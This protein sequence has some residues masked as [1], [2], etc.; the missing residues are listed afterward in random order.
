MDNDC[1][2]SHED[3]IPGI[4]KRAE[5]HLLKNAHKK[6]TLGFEDLLHPIILEYAYQQFRN[7]HLRDAVL[8]SVIAVFEYIRSR[9]GLE[10]DG[11]NLV[12][13]VF[14]LENPQLILSD[15][16]SES[17][18]NDQKGFIQI[19]KGAYQGI[20]NPKAHT[21]VHDLTEEKAAQYLIFASLLARRVEEAK[22]TNQKSR[23]KVSNETMKEPRRPQPE[24]SR[25]VKGEPVQTKQAMLWRDNVYWRHLP[26]GKRKAP[27]ARSAWMEVIRRRGW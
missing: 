7:G 25:P 19:F 21:L 4:G 13:Q 8:N 26:D 3:D 6:Q 14:S 18:Q 11:E 22:P 17:G 24:I 9:T 15:L 23:K 1:R 10:A 16:S 20:R 27:F 12:G 5:K 2:D